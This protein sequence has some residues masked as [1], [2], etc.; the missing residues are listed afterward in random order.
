MTDTSENTIR[1]GFIKLFEGAPTGHGS[2]EIT[3]TRP[4]GKKTGKAVTKKGPASVADFEKHL[5]GEVRLGTVPV[6]EEGM[7]RRGTI[8]LD[9][10]QPNHCPRWWARYCAANA[11]E[12]NVSASKSEGAHLTIFLEE[13]VEA[14][15]LR[16]YLKEK[17]EDFELDIRTERFPKQDRIEDG[18]VGSWINLPYYGETC[19][20]FDEKG[21]PMEIEKFLALVRITPADVIKV[22]TKN[23]ATATGR[24]RSGEVV[25]GHR[26]EDLKTYSVGLLKAGHDIDDAISLLKSRWW[27]TYGHEDQTERDNLIK[28][29]RK[30]DKAG[31]L[32]DDEF[33]NLRRI[34]Y[35]DRDEETENVSGWIIAFR[36]RDVR[37]TSDVITSPT[38]LAKATFDQ[39]GVFPDLKPGSWKKRLRELTSRDLVEVEPEGG[40][41]ETSLLEALEVFLAEDAKDS[42]GRHVEERERVKFGRCWFDEERSVLW[43]N[44]TKAVN[45]IQSYKATGKRVTRRNIL[46]VVKANGGGSDKLHIDGNIK[47]YW[48]WIP[49]DSPTSL[50]LVDRSKLIPDKIPEGA[51]TELVER[52]VAAITK[53]TPY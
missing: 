11:P 26:H 15:K 27:E 25:E 22:R 7:T 50:S 31:G 5:A 47:R 48:F 40:G 10:N 1:D 35:R 17:L 45:R 9:K 2:F 28:W 38:N 44:P 41:E 4:D 37:V 21:E 12:F 43:F 33:S 32:D 18:D 49:W 8:D 51:E 16:A 19:V 20:F 29:L 46:N 30:R 34:V 39:L 42:F 13:P 3:G 14:S 24:V 23:V 6:D 53:K 36:G 52:T